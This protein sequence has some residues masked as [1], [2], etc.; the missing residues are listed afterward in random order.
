MLL[1]KNTAV[2]SAIKK[3]NIICVAKNMDTALTLTH[4]LDGATS[5]TDYSLSMADASHAFAS[6]IKDIYSAPA[7]FHGFKLV[8]VSNDETYGFEPLYMTA[9]YQKVRVKTR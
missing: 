6:I 4:Y 7:V 2:L 3:V 1:E 8:A 9:F 5:G